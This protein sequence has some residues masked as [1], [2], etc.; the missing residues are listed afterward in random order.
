MTQ[1]F[2]LVISLWGFDGNEWVY[3]GNQIV[4]NEPMIKE[5]CMEIRED[6]S[7]HEQNEFYRFSIECHEA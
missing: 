5:E 7:W 4:L 3:V 1:L 6:W 2:V